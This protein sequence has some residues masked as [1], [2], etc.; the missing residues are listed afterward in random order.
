[1]P[2]PRVIVVK[3]AILITWLTCFHV[4]HNLYSCMSPFLRLYCWKF[5][6]NH[7]P[8]GAIWSGG[9][10][11]RCF[12][13]LCREGD[14]SM[15][16]NNNT[17]IWHRGIRAELERMSTLL[18]SL[19][20]ITILMLFVYLYA[21]MATREGFRICSKSLVS[22]IKWIKDGVTRCIM[23]VFLGGDK[24]HGVEAHFLNTARY[25]IVRSHRL[26]S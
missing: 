23:L 5:F 1:M 19:L 13:E 22:L 9:G 12:E 18:L 24:A 15:G 20:K 26:W 25:G 17:H 8:W 4:H 11:L 21:I 6:L 14:A 7:C 3:R 10:V 2:L 16:S